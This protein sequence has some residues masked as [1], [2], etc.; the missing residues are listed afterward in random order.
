MRNPPLK[1]RIAHNAPITPSAQ[2]SRDEGVLIIG[3]RNVAAFLKKLGMPGQ[4]NDPA[5]TSLT[6]LEILSLKFMIE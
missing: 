4:H 3:A 2:S 6:D 5:R 1:T